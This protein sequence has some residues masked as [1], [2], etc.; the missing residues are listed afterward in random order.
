MRTKIIK[1]NPNNYAKTRMTGVIYGKGDQK[2]RESKTVTKVTPRGTR[3][4]AVKYGPVSYYGKQT[5][6]KTITRK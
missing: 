5:K 4:K 1:H 2:I 3:V 6:S